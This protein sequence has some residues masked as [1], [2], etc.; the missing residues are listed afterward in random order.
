MVVYFG[1]VYETK[2]HVRGQGSLNV[3]T[4]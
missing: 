1:T 3:V 2:G 4:H